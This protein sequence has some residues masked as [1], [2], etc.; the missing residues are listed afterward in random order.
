MRECESMGALQAARKTLAQRSTLAST[1]QERRVRVAKRGI[2][3]KRSGPPRPQT[4]SKT[5]YTW[6]RHIVRRPKTSRVDCRS[7]PKP[8]CVP[9]ARPPSFAP[10]AAEAPFVRR[11]GAA[12]T[13]ARREAHRLPFRPSPTTRCAQGSADVCAHAP[14]VTSGGTGPR[15]AESS[16]RS[17]RLASASSRRPASPRGAPVRSGGS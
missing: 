15:T 17:C 2:P 11:L 1:G 7:D 16:G 6:S 9:L 3:A 5:L 10:G 12:R 13:P 4:S 8:P 14:A